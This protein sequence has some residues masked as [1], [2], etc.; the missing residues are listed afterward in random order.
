MQ[1]CYLLNTREYYLLDML[2][3]LGFCTSLH[4]LQLSAFR[5]GC[6]PKTSRRIEHHQWPFQQIIFWKKTSLHPLSTAAYC[7]LKFVY[8]MYKQEDL[9]PEKY[10]MSSAE[11]ERTWSIKSEVTEKIAIWKH[12]LN[13]TKEKK[14]RGQGR[15]R[16]CC[17]GIVAL[18]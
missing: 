13:K 17:E 11:I 12:F 7:L 16:Q 10:F 3:I 5:F 14:W 4:H 1:K 15:T 2:K 8:R 6:K 9:L 18:Q